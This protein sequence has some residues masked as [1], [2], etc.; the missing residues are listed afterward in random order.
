MT[1]DSTLW[2]SEYSR[3]SLTQI[4]AVRYDDGD[5]RVILHTAYMPWN[6]DQ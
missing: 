3:A 2:V 6:Y 1:P 4:A 5:G